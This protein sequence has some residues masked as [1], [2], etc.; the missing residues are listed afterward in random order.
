MSSKTNQL[1]AE[2]RFRQAFERL[3]ANEPKASPKGTPVSQNNV[4]KEAG[5]DPS[6]LKKSRFPSLIREIQAYVEL[7]AG[8]ELSSKRQT[9]LKERAARK[10]QKGRLAEVICQRDIAQSQLASAHRRILELV[11]EVKLVRAQLDE[12]RPPPI[13]LLR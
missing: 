5:C 7:H 13:P 3:K 12:L 8:E 11:E 6:A 2:H 10:E 1:T 9:V 4:A